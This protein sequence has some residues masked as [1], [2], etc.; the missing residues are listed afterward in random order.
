MSGEILLT[1]IFQ[2]VVNRT[3]P[4]TTLTLY[5]L[6]I[7]SGS[8]RAGTAYFSVRSSWITPE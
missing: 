5:Q 8:V 1:T 3:V 6:P 7:F 4:L 2:I